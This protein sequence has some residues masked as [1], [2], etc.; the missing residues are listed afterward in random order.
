MTP[1]APRPAPHPSSMSIT[2]VQRWIITVLVVVVVGHLAEALVIFA[3]IAPADKPA[4]RI[5]LLIIAGIVGLLAAGG[6]RAIHRRRLLSPWLFLGL[7]PALIGA[8]LG[9]WS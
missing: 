8:Y 3:L 4:S 7:T 2:Q 9:Y 5:G 1:G 6:V